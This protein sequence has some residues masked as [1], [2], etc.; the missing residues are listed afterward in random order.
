MTNKERNPLSITEDELAKLERDTKDFQ[1]CVL[2]MWNPQKSS[3]I[4]VSEGPNRTRGN[5]VIATLP[6]AGKHPRGGGDYARL[7]I[8]AAQYLYLLPLAIRMVRTQ[9]EALNDI[10]GYILPTFEFEGRQY[11]PLENAKHLR[12]R[13]TEGHDSTPI[14]ARPIAINP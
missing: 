11:V 3:R 2:E 5:L 14:Q 13:A 6:D 9:R 1:P 7:L 4:E 8:A 10:S 12:E